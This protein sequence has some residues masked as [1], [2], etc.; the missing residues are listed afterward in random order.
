MACLIFLTFPEGVWVQ[1]TD[2][3]GCDPRTWANHL[4]TGVNH[5][6]V[7]GFRLT[8]SVILSSLAASVDKKA[9]W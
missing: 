8:R 1:V 5:L 6:S 2:R 9:S 4:M 3:Q 7:L